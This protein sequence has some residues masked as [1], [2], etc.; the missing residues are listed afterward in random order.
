MLLVLWVLA[1][2]Q[3]PVFSQAKTFVVNTTSDRS[4]GNAGESGDDGKCD[5][6]PLTPGDQCPLRA[7][8]QNHN[9][10]RH[11]GQ[12]QILF[13][14]QGAPGTGSI[15]IQVGS[16]TREAL[17][18]VLGSLVMKGVN[19][20]D[21]RRIE[22]VGR[23]A[24]D[25]AIGL[26]LRGGFCQISGFIINGFDSHGI[27]ISGTPPP[28]QGGHT[29]TG[30]FIGTN[31]NGTTALPNGGDGIYIEN[32]PNNQ[33]GGTAA[34]D[35]N[36]IS[37]NL[38]HGINLDGA[39]PEVEFMTNA[40][41]H[42]RIFGNL[43][44]MAADS[45]R[46]LAN[47]A[48][49]ILNEK[50]ANT[51]VGDSTMVKSGNLLGGTKNGITITGSLSEGIRIEGNS[52]DN[53]VFEKFD[54][55]ILGR[56][57]RLLSIAHNT[58]T[59]VNQT[60]IDVFFSASGQYN[61]RKNQFTGKVLQGTK[62]RFGEG[63][64]I[65]VNY[66]NNFHVG[67]GLA[68]DM[69]EALNG[70]I[71]WIFLGNT[72]KDGDRGVRFAFH[73]DGTKSLQGNT[74][75]GMAS[76]ALAWVADHNDDGR[77]TFSQSNNIFTENA[78]DGSQTLRGT[79]EGKGELAYVLVGDKISNSR[80]KGARL[81]IFAD[82]SLKADISIRESEYRFCAGVGLQIVSDGKV[83]PFVRGFV[84]KNL[85]EN[86]VVA[87]IEFLSSKHFFKSVT[88][89]SFH[90]I[91]GPAILVNGN[92][93]V[94]INHN[95][96]T[97]S[98]IGVLVN[99]QSVAAIEGNTITQNGK[100]IV[101]ASGGNGSALL[102]NLIFT[103][104]G[105]GID[106]ANNGM[107]P[108]DAGD[109]DTGPNGLQNFPVLTSATTAGSTTVVNGT[110][111]SAPNKNY[112]IEFFSNAVC[113]SSG[114][115]EGQVFL[116][117]LE[118]ATNAGGNV[119]FTI[120]LSP[121]VASGSFVTA[122]ARDNDNN[123][124]EFSA[125]RQ[126]VGP[127]T[128]SLDLSIAKTAD[129]VV[130]P[131][132]ENVTFTL[133]IKNNGAAQATNIKV[134]D[135]LPATL[136][137]LQA[138][139]SAGEYNNVNGIWTIP[140]LPGGRQAGL[141][142]TAKTISAGPVTNKVTITEADQPDPVGSNNEAI[143]TI[144]VQ[145]TAPTGADLSVA[146]TVSKAVSVIGEEISFTTS[147]KNTGPQPATAVFVKDR[148]PG[149]FL[150]LSV[151]P[152][153]GTYNSTT[154]IWSVGHMAVG[155]EASLVFRVR[156]TRSETITNAATIAGSKPQD[157]NFTNNEAF[158]SATVLPMSPA[159]AITAFIQHNRQGIGIS[160]SEVFQCLLN[161]FSNH[162]V[163]TFGLAEGEVIRLSVYDAAGRLVAVLRSGNMPAVMHA[164]SWYPLNQPA[165][166]YLIVLQKAGGVYTRRVQFM[167]R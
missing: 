53:G 27:L 156:S 88:E 9:A 107:T 159:P 40:A 63:R 111:N 39:D 61:I 85:F 131:A 41:S 102:R 14:I 152:S 7:A 3:A 13:N 146:K 76:T 154:A 123:T 126:V 97:E 47:G 93:L 56:G 158:A 81:E 45:A 31:A 91:S 108:N 147:V 130:L 162:T 112:V 32:T 141:Q 117:S 59:E 149:G 34:E 90:K 51:K 49:G 71:D 70:R 46:V 127:A 120:T 139:P 103:N 95:T 58:F 50:A 1:A 21:K 153:Q 28:G 78:K 68:V 134:Q 96:I 148:L 43:I 10:N 37:G 94:H 160:A 82:V 60:Q 48:G 16:L 65:E 67:A 142:M 167:K 30:N 74:F 18:P 105:L 109:A 8:I 25:G 77:I 100:G 6:D 29:I 161:P 101:L 151:S 72:L 23:D 110:L 133:A 150:L 136:S 73:A 33:I 118:V 89:N 124:S 155:S 121:T 137:F 52:F 83:N 116:D 106:L 122:T 138:L 145:A 66:S 4:D 44:G 165:G 64:E 42:N 22:L 129:R 62:I 125:C 26:I 164:A 119:A 86:D 55:N 5:V 128:V 87:G 163:V 166:S 57:G 19:G 11:L 140:F 99:D 75:S 104:T 98:T 132:G 24:G 115:G 114:F 79:I 69:E 12:N 17:P 80:G 84:E 2:Y 36:V 157:P 135:L 35:R 54:I 15:V 92:S 113:H 38:G 144:L 20:P 143:V